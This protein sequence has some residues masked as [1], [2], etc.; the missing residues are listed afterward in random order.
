MI[1]KHLFFYRKTVIVLSII[2][3]LES[4]FSDKP[5]NDFVCLYIFVS[6]FQLLHKYLTSLSKMIQPILVIWFQQC[7][8][9]TKVIYQ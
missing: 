4:N 8:Q 5:S 6:S 7:V 9:Y 3:K 2:D 1:F